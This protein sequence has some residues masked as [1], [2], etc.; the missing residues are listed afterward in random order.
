MRN[1]ITVIIF[2]ILA[3]ITISILTYWQIF[4]VSYF[5]YTTSV[6]STILNITAQTSKSN[7]DKTIKEVIN[8]IKRVDLI[9][10]PYNEKSEISFVNNESKNG[11][12]NIQISNELY[13]LLSFGKKYSEYSDGEFDITVRPLIELWGFGIKEVQSVPKKNEVDDALKNIGIK[14]IDLKENSDKTKSLILLKSA[15]FDLGA[16][17]KCYILERIIDI[18]KNRGVKN[19]L[20]DYGGDIYSLGVNQKG[21]PWVIAIRKPREYMEG[22]YLGVVKTTNVAIVTSGDY[23]RFF[24]E[25]GTNYNHIIN[26]KTGFPSDNAISATIV[27]VSPMEADALSTLAFLL[28]TN[29]FTN[30]NLNYRE[31]YIVTED[32]EKNISLYAYTNE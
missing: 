13:Y 8:E 27:T 1:K 4:R 12:T 15:Q 23:E 21:N 32:K 29:F 19:F 11:K 14:Y 7:F 9:L 25:N 26:A 6:S 10:N 28:G 22:Q 31:A 5:K 24:T 17:G 18:F 20:I 16:Y 2:I 30:E 3:V